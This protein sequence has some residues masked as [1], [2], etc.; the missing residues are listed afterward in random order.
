MRKPGI[1][2]NEALKKTP[3]KAGKICQGLILASLECSQIT[4]VKGLI[5]LAPGCV[6]TKNLTLINQ[7]YNIGYLT[8][9]NLT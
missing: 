9:R 8:G 4:V 6:F 5:T 3:V 1:Y 2:P 7:N